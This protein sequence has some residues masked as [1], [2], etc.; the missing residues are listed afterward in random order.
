[1][2][3]LPLTL[4]HVNKVEHALDDVSNFDCAVIL[5]AEAL[6]LLNA[7]EDMNKIGMSKKL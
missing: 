6:S 7:S 4:F 1:M 2:R 3:F 5:F